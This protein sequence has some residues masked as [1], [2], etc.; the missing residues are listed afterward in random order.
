VLTGPAAPGALIPDDP[1]ALPQVFGGHGF[2]VG[3]EGPLA[4]GP[5]QFET[6]TGGT[7]AAPRRILR[8]QAS[9][10]A[11][12]AVDAG[13]HGIGPGVRVGVLGR[14]SHSLAL[15][16]VLSGLH[17]GAEVAAGAEGAEVL[18]ATP[19]QLGLLAAPL[20][21][22]R[23]VICGGGP[24]P[25]AL[26]DHLRRLAPQAEVAV[27][28]G[29]AE[30][31]FLTLATAAEAAAGMAGQAY[32]GVALRVDAPDG[33][34]GEIVA[35]SPYVA[36]GYASDPGPARWQG[37]EV[38]PGEWGVMT[39]GAL[40]VLGRAGRMVTVA[41]VNV[42][43]EAVEDWLLRQPGVVAA[44]ALP[45]PDPRRGH[46]IEAAMLGPADAPA[47][48]RAARRALGPAAAPRRILRLDDWPWLAS[49]KTDLRAVEARMGWR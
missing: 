9:W 2:R 7:T 39:Q 37:G 14:L 33:R 11:S 17:L 20:P 4:A 22:L 48:I 26:A 5:G 45:R 1:A 35:A 30:T 19:V 10:I 41:D 12:F 31:S 43:P 3:G 18:W 29:T 38:W 28:Y 15:Y 23:R 46:V 16:G 42:W 36:E 21:R 34:P 27:F 49:G 44:A 47:L 25:P 32:P 8:R 6:L 13:L 40:R 24:F